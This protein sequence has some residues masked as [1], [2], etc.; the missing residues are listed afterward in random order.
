MDYSKLSRAMRLYY[1][2]DMTLKVRAQPFA[3][4]FN[5]DEINEIQLCQKNAPI[6]FTKEKKSLIVYS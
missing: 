2:R 5:M 6:T 4:R 3:Y 1:K